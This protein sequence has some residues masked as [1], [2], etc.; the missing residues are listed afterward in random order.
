MKIVIDI[1][2]SDY[3][4]IKLLHEGITDYQTTLKLYRVVKTGTV[5][6]KGCGDLIDRDALLKGEHFIIKGDVIVGDVDFG[7]REMDV[8]RREVIENAHTVIDADKGEDNE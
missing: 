8:Y 2:E 1:P 6:P 5:L 7:I 4:Y 3:E